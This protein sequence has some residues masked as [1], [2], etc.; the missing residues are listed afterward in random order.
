[1][2]KEQAPTAPPVADDAAPPPRKSPLLLYG[3][4]GLLLLG[5]LGAGGWFLYPR[6][7]GA[8]K[9]GAAEAKVEVPIK[10]TVPLGAVVV[11]LAGDPRRYLRVA[12]GL[13]VPGPTEAKEVEEMK[14]QLLDLLIGVLASA[15]ADALL[16]EEGRAEL[17]AELLSRIR[18]ELR[19]ESVRRVYFTEFVIQ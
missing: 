11:N 9:P 17:K 19:L 18:E 7:F 12:V 5:A 3:A 16:S 10:A 6:F 15:D 4:A 13:G 1:M 8:A 14:P 2:S